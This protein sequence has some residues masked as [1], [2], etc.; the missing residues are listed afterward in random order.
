M[1][2]ALRSSV[3]LLVLLGLI[4]VRGLQAQMDT[5][6]IAGIVADSTGAVVPNAGLTVTNQGTGMV[7][8]SKSGSIGEFAVPGLQVGSYT[9][10]VSLAGFKTET[11]HD[12][13]VHANATASL[14]LVLP[15][16]Q[17]MET[18]TVTASQVMVDTSTSQ[19]GGTITASEVQQMP[20]NGRDLNDLLALVPGS[21]TSGNALQN[22]L[23]GIPTW[24]TGVNMLMDG[25]DASRVDNA[26]VANNMGNAQNRI[27]H[28][29]VDDVQE[30]RI[31]SSD[32]SA[33]FGRSVGD[34]VN[35]ITKSGTNNLHGE[36]FEFLRNDATDA[37]N[38]FA[39]KG[40]P[41]PLRLNQ[42]GA[43]VGGPIKHDKL[44]YFV[45]YE[46]V[47]QVITTA[48]YNFVLNQNMRKLATAALQPVIAQIPAGN[49]GPAF[50]SS[51]VNY[52]YW[53][54]IYN[55]TLPNRLHEDTG[56]VKLDYTMSARNNF[57]FRY[58]INDSDTTYRYNFALDSIEDAPARVQ[59]G[60]FTWNYVG[61]GEF[62][63]E[64]GLAMNRPFTDS[65]AGGQG[66]PNFSCF[67]CQI[68]F[69][70]T[71]GPSG[72]TVISPELSVQAIDTA[73]WMKGRHQIKFGYDLKRNETNRALPMLNTFITSGGPQ[74]NA[75]CVTAG[76]NASGGPEYLLQN[77]N[78]I[79]I[80]ETGYPMTGMWN[81][82][83][84]FFVNDFLRVSRSLSI[85]LGLRYDYNTIL[86][87]HANVVQNFDIATLSLIANNASYY[88]AD[89]T[90]FAPRV[91]FNWDVFNK[92][93]TALKGGYGV[94]YLPMLP[95][96]LLNLAVNNFPNLS[97]NIF[98]TNAF[99]GG[100]VV[101]TPNPTFSYPPPTAFPNCSPQPPQNMTAYDTNARDSYAQH[102]SLGVEQ[103]LQASG[104]LS[105]SYVGNHALR[106]PSQANMNPLNPATG[107]YYISSLYGSITR[108]GDFAGSVYNAMQVNYRLQNFHGLALNLNYT[109]A[110]QKD[111]VLTLFEEYQNPYN[112]HNEWSVGDTD[113]RTTFSGSVI[114]TL[115][116]SKRSPLLKKLTN[117]WQTT[118]FLSAR[119]SLPF[120]VYSGTSS[121]YTN[122]LRANCIPG[123]PLRPSN[124]NA[125]YNALNPA[126][127]ANPAADTF[128]NCPRNVARGPNFFQ[129]DNGLIKDTKIND[130]LSWEFRGEVFNIFNHPNFG[131]PGYV[132]VGQ[133][134]FGGTASTIG[135]FLGVGTSR[136]AQFAAKIIF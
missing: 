26:S 29:S 85:N 46:G 5:G 105:V 96:N 56:A 127:F 126:A 102:Y 12:I 72:L 42:F 106:M 27:Q 118:A 52:G 129:M 7:M 16:G 130:H 69:G 89:Y 45:D 64:F 83:Y 117:G 32:Y 77:V 49:G 8:K 17:T 82:N 47:R 3:G 80:A 14:K 125:A 55:G 1:S 119:S 63:N 103:Q 132:Y 62:L 73:T 98:Q 11:V 24:E 110:K 59:L 60:K 2:K 112:L 116:G 19:L 35:V 131:N 136:Q 90:D 30:I 66:F 54:D 76:C 50:V 25:T 91:G 70:T 40:E 115:P 53:F 75:A 6:T 123:V 133:P 124:Y 48:T 122:T 97:V 84:A 58:N 74:E 104:V 92:G 33:E 121:P 61:T 79:G 67:Y 113:V 39:V 107:K 88:H 101:C 22:S 100:T 18:V 20:L 23:D 114:Y 15:V 87:D 31:L 57:A 41:T 81:T 51:G 108:Q 28:A 78:G 13:V 128:G 134:N 38:Y 135:N 10:S 95:D 94:F 4:A 109:W 120:T 37:R 44:L 9:V 21:V 111:D 43:N 71:P 93:K 65:Y 34:V 68:G 86:H 99:F 36:L